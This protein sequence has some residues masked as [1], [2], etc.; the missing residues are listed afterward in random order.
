MGFIMN[1]T[2][3]V[4]FF[5]YLLIVALLTK[6][7]TY[8]DNEASRFNTIRA[9]VEY[10]TFAWIF[11][12]YNTEDYVL[13]DGKF[14]S[15]KPPVFAFLAAG[16]YLLL[17][18]L[19]LTF[20]THLALVPYLMK[21]LVI[22]LTS[23]YL[24]VVFYRTLLLHLPKKQAIFL[25]LCLGFA[26]L[27]LTYATAFNNHTI[28]ALFLFWAVSLYIQYQRA[29]KMNFFLFGL[30]LGLAAAFD[31]IVGFLFL[32]FFIL[33]FFF[34]KKI[35]WKQNMALCIGAGLPVLL[36]F[37][38]NFM[39]FGDLLPAYAHPQYFEA[40]GTWQTKSNLPG[41]YNHASFKDLFVYT[42]HSTFGFRG[43]F[44]Y[45]PILFFGFWILLFH[46]LKKKEMWLFPIF[47]SIL[48]IIIYYS[49]YTVNYGGASY[50]SRYFLPLTP[51]LLFF[52][53]AIFTDYPRWKPLFYVCAI[54]SFV[55]AVLGA[56]NPWTNIDSGIHQIPILT[57]IDVRM[58]YNTAAH[59]ILN[60]LFS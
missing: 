18:K 32:F 13:I 1:K 8:G 54:F 58:T 57:N 25:T 37:L 30:F 49:I 4:I 12:I 28:T 6:P 31:I 14:Y 39:I 5:F 45:T 41:F 59:Y 60:Y 42:F 47:F 9:L 11:Y 29:E 50:G 2:E 52:C 38:F 21:V 36:H 26:T 53:Y 56:I 16:V 44:S 10:Q 7:F 19:G 23:A 33:Y 24:L 35:T 34:I 15:D 48:A 43:L 46:V 55:V 20:E 27:L 51:V 22:G 40:A 17:T 3:L